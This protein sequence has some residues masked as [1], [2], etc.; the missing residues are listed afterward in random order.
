MR[1]HPPLGKKL[2]HNR[3]AKEDDHLVA[4]ALPRA[5]LARRASIGCRVET[6]A[7]LE[8][9]TAERQH[10]WHAAVGLQGSIRGVRGGQRAPVRLTAARR[11]AEGCW[12]GTV[13]RIVGVPPRVVPLA[14][15]GRQDLVERRVVVP[16]G[17][18]GSE[19]VLV[20]QRLAAV[21]IVL[22]ERAAVRGRRRRGFAIADLGHRM[23]NGGRARVGRARAD[24]V[25]GNG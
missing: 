6:E 13:A 12:R 24:K 2:A 25:L 21:G 10:A 8:A 19:H 18:V 3:V 11:D 5:P 20:M 1:Q 7:R 23:S 14:A 4:Q 15:G 9:R 17:A 22:D 16:E